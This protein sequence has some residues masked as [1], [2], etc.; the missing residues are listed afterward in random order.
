MVQAMRQ[1][2]DA[3]EHPEKRMTAIPIT[4]KSACLFGFRVPITRRTFT[5][6][7][8]RVKHW[9]DAHREER[10]AYMKAW[11]EGRR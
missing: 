7:A 10:K 1:V 4:F 8:E 9:N 6:Q 5:T 2:H 3:P 11:R